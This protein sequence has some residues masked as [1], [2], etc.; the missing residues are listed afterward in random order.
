MMHDYD[1]AFSPQ[2]PFLSFN[3]ISQTR[4]LILCSCVYNCF[5][6]DF[7]CREC[8]DFLEAT[9]MFVYDIE[10]MCY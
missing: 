9:K 1:N 8:I 5:T 3:L 4:M 10:P 2:S 6:I 7:P